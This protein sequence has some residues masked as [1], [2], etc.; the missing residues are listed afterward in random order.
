MSYRVVPSPAA[1]ALLDHSHSIADQ[2]QDLAALLAAVDA[3]P[4]ELSADALRVLCRIDNE[5]AVLVERIGEAGP[6]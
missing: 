4:A 2:A 3:L 1:R 5:L 6:G